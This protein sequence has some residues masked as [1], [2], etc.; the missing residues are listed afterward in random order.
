MEGDCDENSTTTTTNTNLPGK[1]M[2]IRDGP[3]RTALGDVSNGA[4]PDTQV[5]I[6]DDDQSSHLI[7]TR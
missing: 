7:L 4:N 2:G 5:P 6:D 1:M 3:R